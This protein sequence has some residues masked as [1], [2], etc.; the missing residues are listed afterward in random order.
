MWRLSVGPTSQE[1]H[2][3]LKGK[4]F[5]FDDVTSTSS[6]VDNPAPYSL[7]AGPAGNDGTNGT[8]G[9]DGKDGVTTVIR[10][11]GELAGNR[12]RT[13]HARKIKGKEL[14]S[15]RASLRGKRLATHG[16]S[17]TVDLR[18]KTVGNYHVVMVAKYKTKSTGKI[19]TVRT[20]RTLSVFRR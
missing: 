19:H 13:L 15:V 20:I 6:H 5:L 4:G 14:V 18:G 1:Q 9:K 3:A 7:P 10:D 17:V 11:G 16:R 8:D 2:D 12:I